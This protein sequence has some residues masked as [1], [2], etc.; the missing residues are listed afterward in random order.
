MTND[1][2]RKLF[3]NYADVFNAA[4]SG[5]PDL[6]ALA[7]LYEDSFIGAAP[8]GVM[9]GSKGKE[10][11]EAMSAGFDRS[12]KIGMKS[13]TVQGVDVADIDPIHAM[14][15]VDWQAAY[16]TSTDDTLIDFTNV[17]LVREMDG[18]A[19]VF[20]WITGDEEAELKKHGI[21]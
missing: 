5:K 19:Q 10:F 20:G 8:A 9:V 1:A 14:A 15:R 4:L 3:D 17:Y 2:V 18:R 13:M 12:R 6:A 21:V 16:E 7:D 11:E